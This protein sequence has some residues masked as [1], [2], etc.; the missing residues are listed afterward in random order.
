MK[1]EEYARDVIA[2]AATAEVPSR[3]RRLPYGFG[4]T[5]TSFKR[6][7]F[8]VDRLRAAGLIQ[9][10]AKSLADNCK[11]PELSSSPDAS[12]KRNPTALLYP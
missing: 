4:S 10:P 5:S 7:A 8:S 1:T 6:R 12:V 9:G 11:S 3:N 2:A